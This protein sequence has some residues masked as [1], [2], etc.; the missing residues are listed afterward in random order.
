MEQQQAPDNNSVAGPPAAANSPGKIDTD[1]KEIFDQTF[2]DNNFPRL[3]INGMTFRLT[4]A[5]KKKGYIGFHFMGMAIPRPATAAPP[6]A[7]NNPTDGPSMGGDGA[8]G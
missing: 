8:A 1:W 5:S 7:G 4:N 6:T 2:N 3:V